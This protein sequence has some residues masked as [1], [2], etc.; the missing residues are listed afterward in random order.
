M[1]ILTWKK[2]CGEQACLRMKRRGF[3]DEPRRLLP[4]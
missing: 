2:T 1:Q 4:E 3:A